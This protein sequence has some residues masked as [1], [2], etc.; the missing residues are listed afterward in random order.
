ML[1]QYGLVQV[2]DFNQF[3]YLQHLLLT[4]NQVE[5]QK[6]E[7]I[8][9]VLVAEVVCMWTKPCVHWRCSYLSYA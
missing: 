1:I 3:K 7:F 2:V 6:L 9:L 8:L 4:Q 5:L